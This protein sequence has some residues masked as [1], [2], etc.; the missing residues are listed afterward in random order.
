MIDQ[1]VNDRGPVDWLGQVNEIDPWD[2]LSGSNGRNPNCDWWMK[3]DRDPWI[4]LWMIPARIEVN[5]GFLELK[6]GYNRS[7]D[8]LVLS[9]PFVPERYVS[10]LKFWREWL[11]LLWTFRGTWGIHL[12]DT[13]ESTE[14]S[15]S[16]TRLCS[17]ISQNTVIFKSGPT[18]GAVPA[19]T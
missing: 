11:P 18:H 2:P 16:I 13:R 4:D 9:E 1:Y 15:V 10:L 12:H 7:A 19:F 6:P 14:T 5:G 3:T 8:W 17:S